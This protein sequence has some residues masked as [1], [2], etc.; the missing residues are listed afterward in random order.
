MILHRNTCFGAYRWAM[1]G[2]AHGWRLGSD[3]CCVIL[4]ITIV[5]CQEPSA[6]HREE[7]VHPDLRSQLWVPHLPGGPGG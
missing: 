5:C 1:L 3:G 4:L 7:P 2:M 6:E